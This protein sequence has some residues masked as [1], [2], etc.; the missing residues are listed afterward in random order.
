V[1]E[2]DNE[3]AAVVPALYNDFHFVVRLSSYKGEYGLPLIKIKEV[4]VESAILQLN[5]AR[6]VCDELGVL[7]DYMQQSANAAAQGETEIL[8]HCC[9]VIPVSKPNRL[10][11]ISRWR[12]PYLR[13]L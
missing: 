6:V 3:F 4:T 8:A 13:L 2:L 7:V 1:V 12:S 11:G 9:L 10:K 5:A